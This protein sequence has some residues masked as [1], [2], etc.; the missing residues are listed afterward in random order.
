VRLLRPDIVDVSSGVEA[1]PCQKSADRMRA[2]V[3]AA[4]T[5]AIAGSRT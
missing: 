2:F 5:D 4:R 3:Q 1:S